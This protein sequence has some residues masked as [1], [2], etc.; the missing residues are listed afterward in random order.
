MFK[1]IL[2][3]SVAFGTIMG[4]IGVASAK[5]PCTSL[6]NGYLNV[7]DRGPGKRNRGYICFR[8]ATPDKNQAVLTLRTATRGGDWD[9]LV[10]TRFNHKTR[11]MSGTISP[12]NNRGTSDEI[13]VLPTGARRTYDVVVFPRTS[14]PSRGCIYYHGFDQA[15]VATEA[16]GLATAQYLLTALFSGSND[17]DAER[18]NTG[19]AV[20]VGMSALRNRNLG[21]SGYDLAMNEISAELADTF[22]GG[23]WLFAFGVNYFS[24]YL[25]NIASYS[26]KAG[27]KCRS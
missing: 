18:R 13:V 25:E 1:F 11:K 7:E 22:G 19:R 3:A 23:S 9:I 8:V 17:T 27:P 4:G 12:K 16:L 2:A 20:T 15:E 10:G 24:G 14:T 5:E 6:K 21:E 26:V